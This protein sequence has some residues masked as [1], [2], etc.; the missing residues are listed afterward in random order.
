MNRKRTEIVTRPSLAIK[1][2]QAETGLDPL[3][4][5]YLPAFSLREVC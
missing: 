2:T 4:L 5:G 1:S 3:N